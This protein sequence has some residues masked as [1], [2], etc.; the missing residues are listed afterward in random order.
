MGKL[1]EMVIKNLKVP[2]DVGKHSDGRGLYL[3]VSKTGGK[4]WRFRYEI[5]A[6]GR[7]IEKTLTLG[8]YPQVGLAQARRELARQKTLL[9]EG[10]DPA[11]K[12][13]EDKWL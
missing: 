8:K 9:A 6:G 2:D 7:R 10:G 13:K 3:I 11:A 5:K 1:T 4:S 12:R